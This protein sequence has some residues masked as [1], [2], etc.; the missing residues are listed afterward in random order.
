MAPSF[1][2]ATRGSPLALR[3]A[4]MLRARLG[5]LTGADADA[6]PLRIIKTS[7]LSAPRGPARCARQPG[8]PFACQAARRGAGR[9]GVAAPTGPDQA[10]AAGAGAGPAARECRPQARQMRSR[11]GG[12]RGAGAGGIAAPRSRRSRKRDSRSRAHAARAGSGRDRHRRACGRREGLLRPFAHRRSDDTHHH[13]RRTGACGRAGCQ[14]PNPHRRIGAGAG[15]DPILARPADQPRRRP[16]V[17][18]DGHGP[19]HGR[20]G[21]RL[22]NRLAADLRRQAGPAF[23]TALAAQ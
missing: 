1:T 12:C 5:A 7:G 18:A 16:D 11:R 21:G 6:L 3:Q 17:G 15:C 20:G 19:S 4:E 2:I 9:H 23:F 13:L 14:L 10:V 22:G 8:G